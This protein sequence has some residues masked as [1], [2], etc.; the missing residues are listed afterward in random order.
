MTLCNNLCGLKPILQPQPKFPPEDLAYLRC[1]QQ[2]W[3]HGH[4]HNNHER[5][6]NPDTGK[7]E[8]ETFHIAF[9]YID[10]ALLEGCELTSAVSPFA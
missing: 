6:L 9:G 3:F 2:C 8:N 10:D 5:Y 7:A 4:Y 1:Q